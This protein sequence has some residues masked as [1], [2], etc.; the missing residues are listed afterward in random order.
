MVVVTGASCKG[1]NGQNVQVAGIKGPTV[2][3]V[4]NKF[5]MSIVF[6]TVDFD[7]GVRI[8]LHP[9]KMPN[10]YIEV[11]PDFA[12]NGLLM[13]LAVDVADIAVLT[14]G[15]I[16]PLDPLT[17]PGG[18]PLPGV[19]QGFLPGIA[20]TV[21]KW[22]NTAFYVGKSVFG[23]FIPLPIPLSQIVGTFRFY[24]GHGNRVGNLS[25]VGKDEAGKNS[26]L[27][28]LIDLKGV[29]GNTVKDAQKALLH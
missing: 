10:S 24:D 18:R 1:G 7:G 9:Q 25:V 16:V 29:V 8:P 13:V 14:G 3:M 15:A 22:K 21:P 4:D 2:T 12:S 27:L 17:L 5:L 26:G 11:G 19:S 6:E 28:V 20:V 23:A